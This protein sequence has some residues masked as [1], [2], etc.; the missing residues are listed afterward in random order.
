M[1]ENEQI[2]RHY[3]IAPDSEYNMLMS[4]LR[5][6]VSRHL[7]DEHFTVVEANP[8]YYEIIGYPK[9]EYETLYHN[10]CDLYFKNNPEDWAS[11]VR[12]VE[13][14]QKSVV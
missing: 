2:L 8:Y 14:D 12:A 3:D 13:K 9:E 5:V 6:S 11:I 1:S 4:V 10:K 7:M